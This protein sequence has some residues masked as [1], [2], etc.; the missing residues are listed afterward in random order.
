MGEAWDAYSA[1]RQD[2]TEWC[3]IVFSAEQLVIQS[4]GWHQPTKT[5]PQYK[6]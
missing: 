2:I 4:C 3:S 1:E 6:I 5:K